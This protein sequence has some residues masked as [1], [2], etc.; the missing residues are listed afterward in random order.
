MDI[1][2]IQSSQGGLGKPEKEVKYIKHTN[3][4]ESSCVLSGSSCL[5]SE[6]GRVHFLRRILNSSTQLDLASKQYLRSQ[7]GKRATHSL[8]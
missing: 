2:K 8:C 3:N 4:V 1:I 6:L 7:E 5:N